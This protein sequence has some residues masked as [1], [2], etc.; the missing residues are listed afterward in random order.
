MAPDAVSSAKCDNIRIGSACDMLCGL[1]HPDRSRR[2]SLLRAIR[3]EPDK[4]LSFGPVDGRDLIDELLSLCEESRGTA[5][6]WDY[7]F[8]TLSL[9]DQRTAQLAKSEFLATHDHRFLVISAKRLSQLPEAEKVGF[10]SPVILESREVN[11]CRLCANVLAGSSLL[12]PRVSIRVAAFSDRPFTLPALDSGTLEAW[13]AELQGPCP[14]RAR[15]LI[16]KARGDALRVLLSFWNRLPEQ[17]RIWTLCQGVENGAGAC[18]S[19]VRDTI[20]QEKQGELLRTALTCLRKL[21]PEDHD[22]ALL[23][24]LY[25]HRD[26]AIRAA[27]VGAGS[28]AT[29]CSP[30]LCDEPCEDVRLAIVARLDCGGGARSIDLLVSLLEDRSWRV[31]AR[32]VDVLVKL[33]PASLQSLRRTLSSSHEEAKVAAVQALFRLGREDWIAEALL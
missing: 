8:T 17:I 6:R 19:L 16:F 11:R 27:A 15:E 12:E 10:L 30:L 23:A 33:A 22:E 18:A 3:N 20:R 7:V 4:A 2:A 9:D 1:R 29:D 5:D 28:V 26:P 21:P 32:A 31:R 13:V 14:Q 24:P 25:G